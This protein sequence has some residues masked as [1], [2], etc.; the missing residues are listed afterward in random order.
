[1]SINFNVVK[2][3]FYC[4]LGIAAGALNFVPESCA[5]SSYVLKS[6]FTEAVKSTY[7]GYYR[8]ISLSPQGRF[9]L[10]NRNTPDELSIW[11]LKNGS[12]F[13]TVIL[14]EV[15][16]DVEIEKD[17]FD[18]IWNADE[19]HLA[20]QYRA[21]RHVA[22]AVIDL[23][24]GE[25]SP[26]YFQEGVVTSLKWTPNGERLSF[27]NQIFGGEKILRVYD[28][29]KKTFLNP[30][31]LKTE[32][33]FASIGEYLWNSSATFVYLE[34]KTTVAQSSWLRFY[35]Y[36]SLR[37]IKS[38]DLPYGGSGLSWSPNQ[39]YLLVERGGGV[40]SM[41]YNSHGDLLAN[42]PRH[43]YFTAMKGATAWSQ[44]SKEFSQFFSAPDRG[45]IDKLYHG[46]L[47]L[48]NTYGLSR[49]VEIKIE[50]RMREAFVV[51]APNKKEVVLAISGEFF[52]EHIYIFDSE[53]LSLKQEITYSGIEEHLAGV[54][55]NADA[56]LQLLF[57][58]GRVDIYEQG[59]L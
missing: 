22:L 44:D 23:Q 29:K 24:N 40:G 54:S 59:A 4:G 18:F 51:W 25:V 11:D 57:E 37:H 38:I 15:F 1:M 14:T 27:I 30:V 35:T 2:G 34:H 42:F 48:R 32:T 26:F 41:V 13:K 46:E 52:N 43:P 36:P 10:G 8:K 21:N 58:T 56:E 9:L 7:W 31:S 16:P 19:S 12:H 53:T 28:V 6:S 50:N 5:Q 39:K 45:K 55:F 20:L 3:I 33:A 47:L 17:G 49:Q